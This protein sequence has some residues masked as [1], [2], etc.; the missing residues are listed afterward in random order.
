MSRRGAGWNK[1]SGRKESSSCFTDHPFA[2]AVS[3]TKPARLKKEG[4]D[5]LSQYETEGMEEWENAKI[6]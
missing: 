4:P 5:I 1:K 3:G 2:V 6:N